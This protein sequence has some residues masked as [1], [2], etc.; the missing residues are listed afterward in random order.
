MFQLCVALSIFNFGFA[1]SCKYGLFTHEV[2]YFVD[3]SSFLAINNNL[4]VGITNF[5]AEGWCSF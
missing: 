3:A 1:N 5:S 2:I 4:V